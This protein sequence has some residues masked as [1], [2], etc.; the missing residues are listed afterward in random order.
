MYPDLA[1]ENTRPLDNFK[2]RTISFQMSFCE[3]SFN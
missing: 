2:L 1:N 3:L